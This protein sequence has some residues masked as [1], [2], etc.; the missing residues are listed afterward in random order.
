[1][2]IEVVPRKLLSTKSGY[3]LVEERLIIWGRVIR[4]QRVR[5]RLAAVQL[6][7]RIDIS[8]ATLSR[9]ERGDPSVSV[10]GD[11]SAFLVLGIFDIAMPPL[12]YHLWSGDEKGRVR[13]RQTEV[14]D[15]F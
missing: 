13:T 5:Q 10:A 14:E 9:M 8:R 2:L 4:T 7:D 15:Y 12:D 6:C 3:S 1:M 11:M